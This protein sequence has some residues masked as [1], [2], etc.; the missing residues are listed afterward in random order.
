VT[1]DDTLDYWVDN[2]DER[3]FDCADC[4]MQSDDEFEFATHCRDKHHRLVRITDN[5]RHA[6]QV[7]LEGNAA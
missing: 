1:F 4:G 2:P 5:E 7:W 6:Y 3:T